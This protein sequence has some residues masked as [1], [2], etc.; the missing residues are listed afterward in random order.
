MA[1]QIKGFRLFKIIFSLVV[2]AVSLYALIPSQKSSPAWKEFNEASYEQ[3]L[4]SNKKMI[5]DFYADWCI[6][7][8]E[9]DALTFSDSRVIEKSNEFDNYKVDMTQTLSEETEKISKKFNIVGMPTV[10]IIDSKGNEVAR[11]TGFV[12]AEEFLKIIERVQ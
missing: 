7:C 3:S 10:L 1:N 8:K 12:N 6:P 4:A 11:L 5:I 9:L 2:A